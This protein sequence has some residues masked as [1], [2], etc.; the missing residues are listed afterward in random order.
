MH[1]VCSKRQMFDTRRAKQHILRKQTSLLRI[2]FTTKRQYLQHIREEQFRCFYLILCAVTGKDSLWLIR[3]HHGERHFNHGNVLASAA[4][5]ACAK[6]GVGR[7]GVG[8]RDLAVVVGQPL[9][10][11]KRGAAV[12]N[13]FGAL[14]ACSNSFVL[15]G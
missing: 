5:G 13:G 2:E 7:V 14:H 6:D 10:R 3:T 4:A 8:E 9:L 1:C 15:A 12:A 11:V